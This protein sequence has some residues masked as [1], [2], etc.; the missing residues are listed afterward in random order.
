[1]AQFTEG[2]AYEFTL[3]QIESLKMQTNFIKCV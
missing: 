3:K 1:M 2:I